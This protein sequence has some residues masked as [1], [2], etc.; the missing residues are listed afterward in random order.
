M[1]SP[2]PLGLWT[3]QR[4]MTSRRSSPGCSSTSCLDGDAGDVPTAAVILSVRECH[5][6]RR[7]G[8]KGHREYLSLLRTGEREAQDPQSLGV[9]FLQPWVRGTW[10]P[11]EHGEFSS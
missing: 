2:P 7:V 3:P 11:G 9:G 6:A 5:H 10:V 4:R 1:V 8:L